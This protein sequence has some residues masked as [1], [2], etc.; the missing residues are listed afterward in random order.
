[1]IRL[2]KV[3]R[4]LPLLAAYEVELS[5]PDSAEPWKPPK[6]VSSWALKRRLFGEGF[7]QRDVADLMLEAD[8]L[9]VHAPGEWVEHGGVRPDRIG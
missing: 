8:E 5:P 3:R 9:Y 2:R 4:S 1:M 6:P 7:H